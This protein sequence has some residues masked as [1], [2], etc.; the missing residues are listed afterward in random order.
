[1]PSSPSRLEHLTSQM[2][3]R[4][5]EYSQ[6]IYM[7]GVHDDGDITGIFRREL[8]ESLS[9]LERMCASVGGAVTG[10]QKFRVSRM[11]ELYA[12]Q[13]SIHRTAAAATG[14]GCAAGA[15]PRRHVKVAFV[16]ASDSGKSTLVG[17][18]SSGSLDDGCGALRTALLR[19]RHEV[20]SGHTS[21]VAVDFIPFASGGE[22]GTPAVIRYTCDGIDPIPIGVQRQL[23]EAQRVS[24]LV[25]LAGEEKFLKTTYGSLTS[26]ASPNWI[27]IVCSAVDDIAASDKVIELILSLEL[28]FFLVL[29]KVDLVSEADAMARVAELSQRVEALRRKLY[30]DPPAPVV[31]K[32]KAAAALPG[33]PV[34]K[35]RPKTSNLSIL[36]V[37]S[38]TG[39]GMVNLTSHFYRLQ[40][41]RNQLMLAHLF[42]EIPQA[43]AL[44]AVE[45]IHHVDEVGVVIY[46]TLC[47]GTYQLDSPQDASP[48]TVAWI[49]PFPDGSLARIVVKS[50]HRM[51]L[52]VRNISSGQMATLAVEGVAPELLRKGMIIA[53]AP[54]ARRPSPA[55]ESQVGGEAKPETVMPPT[56][57]TAMPSTPDT[58]MPPTPDTVMTSSAPISF[59]PPS[60]RERESES[61][62]NGDLEQGK[63]E[64]SLKMVETLEVDVTGASP[65]QVAAFASALSGTLYWMG[66]RYACQLVHLQEYY[67]EPRLLASF[68]LL[69]GAKA[70]LL[71]GSRLIFVTQGMRLAGVI[72]SLA[73][74]AED[75]DAVATG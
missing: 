34:T 47:H 9:N 17:A 27:C 12:A 11:P 64:I 21:S 39:D 62:S 13:V 22:G 52:P 71:P 58:A 10:V 7:V 45:D 24:Q 32:G 15:S 40:P 42:N 31:A 57:D 6:C 29:T 72:R 60:E 35:P 66:G 48:K 68:R 54:V 2:L 73:H 20:L 43:T 59:L 14:E 53:F 46:G 26:W 50:M 33:P 18:L 55:E 1:M 63:E 30:G 70:P 8:E 28:P 44:F 36:R 4:L 5:T 61:K 74:G 41:R 75:D 19:H 65:D 51:R 67:L 49:G 16:G 56:P 3:W 69:D 38:L 37:S 25:D 23:I